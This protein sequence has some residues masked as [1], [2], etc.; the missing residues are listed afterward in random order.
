MPRLR[1]GLGPWRSRVIVGLLSAAILL[2]GILALQAAYAYRFHREIAESV[3]RDYAQLIADEFIRRTSVEVGYR[4]YFAAL[5][6]LQQRIDLASPELPQPESLE[7]GVAGAHGLS[8]RRSGQHVDSGAP[9]D[10]R[11]EQL[12]RD[13]IFEA[14]TEAREGPQPPKTLHDSVGERQRTFIFAPLPVRIP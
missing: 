1:S 3:V 14:N 12:L 11:I 9:W 2:V 10:D 13:A 4:G 6:D 7:S 5:T 8:G